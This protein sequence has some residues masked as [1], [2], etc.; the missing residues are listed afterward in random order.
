MAL[1]IGYRL[2]PLPVYNIPQVSSLFYLFF[3][4]MGPA[5][6]G[7]RLSAP[8][9]GPVCFDAGDDLVAASVIIKQRH[10]HNFFRPR[11]DLLRKKFR[12]IVSTHKD[13]KFLSFTSK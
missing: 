1:D 3:Y 13:K 7:V 9:S 2:F 8:V 11:A 6:P 4:S 10:R 12:F 5:G